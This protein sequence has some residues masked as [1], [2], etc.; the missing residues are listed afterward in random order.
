MDKGRT[1]FKIMRYVNHCKKIFFFQN[2]K[3]SNPKGI[4]K[5]KELERLET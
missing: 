3:M 4:E 1:I 5:L 2:I